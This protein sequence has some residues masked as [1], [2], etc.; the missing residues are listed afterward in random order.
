MH[1]R[2]RRPIIIGRHDGVFIFRG[3][4][5]VGIAWINT[6]VHGHHRWLAHVIIHGRLHILLH[7]GRSLLVVRGVVVWRA[8][9]VH[10]N[11]G[12]SHLAIVHWW[13]HTFQVR[14]IVRVTIVAR[15]HFWFTEESS[16]DFLYERFV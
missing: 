13:T 5:P 4:S 12:R 16:N 1:V 2:F 14:H 3:L 6:L 9:G 10:V 7:I 8:I 11:T 15:V